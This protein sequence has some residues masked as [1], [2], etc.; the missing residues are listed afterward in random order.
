MIPGSHL[1]SVKNSLG[2]LRQAILFSATLLRVARLFWLEQEECG[3]VTRIFL[4]LQRWKLSPVFILF[5][6]N[7]ANLQW[8][9]LNRNNLEILVLP[10]VS[11]KRLTNT[12]VLPSIS[13]NWTD[14]PRHIPKDMH[15]FFTLDHYFRKHH[16]YLNVSLV[17]FFSFI[18]NPPRGTPSNLCNS[19]LFISLSYVQSLMI[20]KPFWVTILVEEYG[21][22]S[23]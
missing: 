5:L 12:I 2:G 22:F 14:V 15:C 21:I 7:S 1:C 23:F 10:Q 20:Y 4:F 6:K 3:L 11:S 17:F 18:F 13:N 19:P 9:A 16:C 8:L